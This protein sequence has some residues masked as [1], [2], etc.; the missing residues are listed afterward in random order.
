M[1]KHQV[2]YQSSTIEHLHIEDNHWSEWVVDSCVHPL[3]V[4]L[5]VASLAGG[6]PF[7]YLLYALPSTARRNDGRLR[8]NYLH[9]YT[10][11]E[12]GGWW[13]SGLDPLN[14]WEP[15]LWGRFKPDFPRI[16]FDKGKV[17]KYESPLKTSNRV[18]YFDIPDCIWDLVAQRYGI[19]RYHSPLSLLLGGRTKPMSFWEWV[20]R[21]PE[22]PI[23]LCEGEKKAAA[24]LSMGFV[25]IALPGIWNGRVGKRDFNERLHPDIIPVAQAGRKFI[26]LFDY[27]T[28]PKTRYA[29][30]QAT[31]RT[32]EAIA[33]AGCTCE[34]ATLPGP[35]KGVD[36][37]I[38]ANPEDANKQITII[39]N[40]A[41]SLEDYRQI[42]FR[43]HRGLSAKY[44]PDKRVCVRYLSDAVKELP[45]S[46]TVVLVSE[47]GTGKTELARKQRQKYPQSRFLNI[48]HRVN[49]LKNLAQRLETEMYSDLGYRSLAE[50]KALS[51]TI[52]SL[53]K[54]STQALQYDCVFIDE[55][56]QCLVH[57]LM[58]QTCKEHRAIILEILEYIIFQAKLVIIA[59]AH[60]DDVTL[61]FI[62]A[63]RPVGEKPF[64]V[65]NEWRNP[66]R[67][68]YWYE[69]N[70]SSSL[71]AQ[72]G[73]QIVDGKKVLIA[74]D[75]KRF[76]EKLERT[77]QMSVQVSE[78]EEH[79]ST[80]KLKIWSI[81]SGNSGSSENIAF[82]KDI[83][84]S[85]KDV[86]VLC[87][88]PS[89]G[90]GVDMS[91]YHFDLIFG[92]F[93]ARTQTA[94]ECAQ[95]LYRYRP[96]VPMH[97]WVAPR[98]M[99]GYQETNSE[100]IQQNLLQTNEVTAYLL[101]IDR[102]T[103]TR[104]VEKTW[105]LESYCQIKAN[106][107][108][109][110]NNLRADLYFLLEEMGNTFVLL[111]AEDSDIARQQLKEA[112]Q[113]LDAEYNSAVSHA[114][115]I[116]ATEYR[117]RQS[118][119][120]LKPEEVFECEKHRI[121]QAYGIWDVT[122]ELVASDNKGK[123]LKAIAGLEAILAPS[124]EMIL[125]D[126]KYHL[127]PPKLVAD[128][129]RS[130]RQLYPLCFDWANYSAQWLVR[131]NLGLQQILQRLIAGESATA[132]D[133]DIVQMRDIALNFRGPIKSILGLTVPE[134]CQPIWLLGMLLNSL[135]LKLVSCKKGKRGEQVKLYTLSKP[136]WEFA[137]RAI[138]YREGKRQ[139]RAAKVSG[140]P[141][142]YGSKEDS[143]VVS[144]PPHNISKAPLNGGVNT[145]DL[146]MDLASYQPDDGD[147][148]PV[149]RCIQLLREAC[150][151]GKL[152]IKELLSKWSEIRRWGVMLLLEKLAADEIQK[153]IQEVPEFLAWLNESV[154]PMTA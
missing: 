24:L 102:A 7:D 87:Y 32:A 116:S 28:K 26:I 97:I 90:T 100:K 132:S 36:D 150:E 103:G 141:A 10:H 98:P 52:D 149:E 96:N 2:T 56:C 44:K 48:G 20:Q 55:T 83:T 109:S 46:G 148:T 61:E 30:F 93:H 68:I 121:Q 107:H 25:A 18:T 125:S 17:I 84:N 58:S 85:I 73:A 124:E 129:D 21:H 41:K 51:I 115:N 89:L 43:S 80:Q 88:S 47:M 4:F 38:K 53:H 66:P 9:R 133:P 49:L 62:L 136:E 134:K 34:I 113:L 91:E 45:E 5:N 78:E 11:I 29:V 145:S 137:Q 1:S 153:L 123:L 70:D 42:F 152:A 39:I 69:G 23:I 131:M 130:E 99:M 3:L 112:A 40:D 122:E 146:G 50:A 75:S 65:K 79:D 120:H 143:T 92:V 16:D 54:L 111:G 140:T 71:V 14:N 12:K 117:L 60:M 144:T 64:I 22:I 128:K 33:Q 138:A 37:F 19:K 151:Q 27:E 114:K 72:M 118:R 110:I 108:R 6:L 15:M 76:I 35:E 82:I 81:H 119:D 95:M 106:R 147:S 135:G 57:T 154:L 8:D 67:L 74:S 142:V 105:A 101:R 86:D 77:L 13:V 126:G 59:D 31:V 63:M 104:G 127:T 139:Q 94:T